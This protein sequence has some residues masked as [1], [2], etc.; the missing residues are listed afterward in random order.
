MEKDGLSAPSR[1]AFVA[2][3]LHQ[4]EHYKRLVFRYWWIP[5]LLGGACF[6]AEWYFLKRAKPSF[7]SMG[8]MTVNVKVSMPD[9]NV[10]QDGDPNNFYGTQVALME[11][12]SVVKR[13]GEYMRT[14]HAEMTP[15]PVAIH[16]S[17]EPKTSLF[18]LRATGG[19]PQYTQ[20]YLQ[21]TMDEYI[22]LKRDMLENASTATH[23]KMEEQKN[24]I[25]L[26]LEKSKQAVLDY[27]ASNNEVFL[28]AADG[29]TPAD[30]LAKLERDLDQEKTELQLRTRLTLDQNLEREQH[31]AAQQGLG[32]T[33]A[34]AA[35]TATAATDTGKTT[36][37]NAGGAQGYLPAI[38]GDDEQKYLQ[39]KENLLVAEAERE[40]LA[41]GPTNGMN[42][43]ALFDKDD[44]IAL[45]KRI[46]EIFQ[47]EAEAQMTNHLRELA[48]DVRGKE[49]LVKEWKANALDASQKLTAFRD[50]KE[51]QSRDQ[52]RFDKIQNE[53]QRLE[54]EEGI[55]QDGVVNSE[56]ASVAT[57]VPP[58]DVKHLVV[59]V[60][61]G[62]LLGV[63]VLLFLD[64][65]DDRAYTYTELEQLF[66]LPVLGQFPLMKVK[67]DGTPILRLDD[68]RYPVIESYRSMRSALL[69][70]HSVKEQ[71][72]SIMITSARPSDG[73][74]TVS[75]NFA[76]TLA[77]AGAHVLLIDAD[78]RRGV[79]HKNFSVGAS[80]GFAEVL[81]GRCDWGAAVVPTLI[82]NLD[83][84][85]CGKYAPDPGHLFATAGRYL[86]DIPRNYDYYIF[87]TVPVMV[88]DDV[89]S[90]APHVDALI[91]VIRAGFTSG[92]LARAALNSLEAR[93][94]KVVG[95]V[96]NGVQPGGSDYYHYKFK[97]YYP[98]T[99]NR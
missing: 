9:G 65:L 86:A 46:L 13:V 1:A 44:E 25:S 74:S 6:G 45:K 28:Q 41:A 15:E 80:P 64:R 37:P 11:S 3:F 58:E 93:Q 55:G 2:G 56:P 69:Y 29:N 71:P 4:L 81:G 54:V 73:K 14:N 49:N 82:P 38:L 8:K 62:L 27:Q 31:A 47:Q 48:E 99:A 35:K 32:T 51:N 43:K 16:V 66:D 36:R 75:S 79:L 72:K 78:L 52:T 94:V 91:M 22:Q 10:I 60:I 21:A 57:M 34:N 95:L 23:A 17:I 26:D 40:A 53:L 5:L 89:L 12:D 68:D 85:P 92:R 20:T 24:Q 87:D 30:Y 96:F 84:L 42:Q 67:K 61:T 88:G 59:A 70:R 97:D 18:D 33:P 90:L 76:V 83:L 50:L 39:A 63:G 77:L 19:S 98:R 7:T